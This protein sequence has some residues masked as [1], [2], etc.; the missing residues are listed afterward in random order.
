MP[1]VP[2]ILL[3]LVLM[4][5]LFGLLAGLVFFAKGVIESKAS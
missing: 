2:L 4:I 1:D 5:G 3:M